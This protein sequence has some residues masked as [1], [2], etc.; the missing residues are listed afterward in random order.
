MHGIIN[1][2]TDIYTHSNSDTFSKAIVLHFWRPT[3]VECITDITYLKS[4]Y[5]RLKGFAELVGVVFPDPIFNYNRTMIMDSVSRYAIKYRITTA[6]S[7]FFEWL[8]VKDCHTLVI[9]DQGG[10]VLYS[11][12]GAGGY[13]WFE[14]AL[15]DILG[16]WSSPLSDSVVKQL[17]DIERANS[18]SPFCSD[19]WATQKP[20]RSFSVS[21]EYVLNDYSV[22]V[23]RGSIDFK[24][25]GRRLYAFIEPLQHSELI[26]VR[27]NKHPLRSHLM[28][29]DV[30]KKEG[31]S[32][33]KLDTPR[34]YSIV[35][36]GWGEYHLTL[37]FEE[38]CDVYALNVR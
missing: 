31:R 1:C 7:F 32:F 29:D 19:W 15:R 17:E 30:I 25:R 12:S 16:A 18:L 38:P 24:Y 20:W 14:T 6:E 27:L 9:V 23:N 3:C 21:G 4:I 37:M 36:G 11:Q 34:L 35:D 8:A 10:R 22:R 26:E 28:G 5:D 13:Y 2:L 33:I